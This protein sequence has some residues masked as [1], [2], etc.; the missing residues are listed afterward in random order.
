MFK[1]KVI[2]RFV[3]LLLISIMTVNSLASTAKAAL[4]NNT[5]TITV[6]GL[7][8]GVTVTAYG[9]MEENFDFSVQQPSNFQYLW[10][11]EM[12]SWV[13]E[14]YPDYIDQ[15]N[16][17]AVTKAFSEATDAQ[18]AEFY[19]KLA[20]AIKIGTVTLVYQPIVAESDSV[21]FDPVLTGN[22]MILVENGM[23]V[24]R[25]LTANVLHVWK[26]TTWQIESA[27]VDAKA[28]EPTITKTVAEDQKKDHYT[29][30]DTIHYELSAVIPTYPDNA[31]AKQF[32]VSDKL[33]ES[34]TL[35]ADSIKVYGVNVGE[36]PVLL[37]D[38]YT[39]TSVR[40]AGEEDEKA[41]TFSLNFKYEKISDYA[42]LKITYDAVL[43]KAAVVGGDGNINQAYLDYNN[44]PYVDGSWKSDEDQVTVYTYG[45]EIAKVD[46]DN[47]EPL[48][49]AS[50]YLYKDGEKVKFINEN[51][52]YRVAMSNEGGMSL[53]EVNEQGMLLLH[54]L[55]AG[56]YELEE[57]YAPDGY[58]KLQHPV[59]IVISDED[60]DGK[61]E[62]EGEE[63]E[64]G[65]MTVTVKN[66]KGFTL[67]VT[68]GIGTVLFSTTGILM[69]GAGIL[70]IIAVFRRNESK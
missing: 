2:S 51:G 34:L 16:M 61:V 33:P 62:A 56:T 32:V 11:E 35:S 20:A 46:E 27:V 14:N 42:S 5:G 12:V 28:S 66:G 30:G 59:T 7:E 58:V 23:R 55:D 39:K 49:G 70:L 18:I 54:G 26:D 36:E 3:M 65:V 43:N 22:Y 4:V 15:E 53:L 40:P 50:F 67:P 13:A 21:I 9:I 69:M 29:L 1:R 24:Y 68:G 10:R 41:V 52:S 37:S 31:I 38:S 8:T 19:D 44:N 17:N 63:L 47:E 60:L 25:P 45:M 6:N 48:T 64:D 57:E